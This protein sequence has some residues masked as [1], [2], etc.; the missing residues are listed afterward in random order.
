MAV[1]A[2]GGTGKFNIGHH[3]LIEIPV[4][5]GPGRRD[6]R[7]A[8]W[9]PES[10]PRGTEEETHSDLDVYV[11]GPDNTRRDSS[12]LY[13]SIFERAAVEGPLD[14][15]EWRPQIFGYQ[16]PAGT[17]EFFLAATVGFV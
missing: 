1:N 3:E 8:L 14:E 15:G 12:T 16:V 11:I 13:E 5:I 2:G 4:T 6:F 10:K 7:V 9:W 17:Q